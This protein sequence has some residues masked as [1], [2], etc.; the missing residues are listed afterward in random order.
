VLQL[1]KLDLASAAGKLMMTTLAAVAD[2]ERDLMVER[3]QSSLA[4]AKSEGETLGRPSKTTGEQRADTV[5]KYGADES[6]SALARIYGVSHI[7]IFGVANP[8]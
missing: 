6:V 7:N 4:R 1:G 8:V 5:A 3:A 2:M